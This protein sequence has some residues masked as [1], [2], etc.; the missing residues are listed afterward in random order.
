MAYGGDIIGVA[1]N[2]CV[3]GPPNPLVAPPPFEIFVANYSTGANYNFGNVGAALSG[4]GSI[5]HAVS[6]GGIANGIGS[7]AGGS[8]QTVPFLP[9]HWIGMY[10][11]GFGGSLLNGLD[12]A[13]EGTIYLHTVP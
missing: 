6:I 12:I 13:I 4:V 7:V 5:A 8:F 10:V 3:P 11:D 1:I 9:G 2:L